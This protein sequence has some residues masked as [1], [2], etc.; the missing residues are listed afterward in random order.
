M[1][2]NLRPLKSGCWTP[3]RLVSVIAAAVLL[4]HGC[5]VSGP[6]TVS[7]S[8]S[9]TNLTFVYLHGFGG[10]KK[11]PAFCDNLKTFIDETECDC[12][13]RNYEWDSVD[14]AITRAGAN[15][16]EA[17]KRAD[18]EAVRFKKTVIN[19][20]ER[21][22]TPYVLVGFSIGSRVIL[23]AM[24]DS[25]GSLKFLRGIYFL[26][27]AMTRDTSINPEYL[28]DGMKIINYHSPLRDKVHRMAFNF[29]EDK[30]AGGCVGFG[31]E[32]VFENYAVSCTHAHKGV[33]V[34]ID[35]SQLAHA[36]GY[37]ALLKE[38]IMIPGETSFNVVTPVGEG[39][40]WWNKI[41]RM[42]YVVD[43]EKNTLE[44]EQ[45]NINADYFRAVAVSPDG[46]RRR[47]ARG[48]NIHAILEELDVMPASYWRN[49]E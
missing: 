13:V 11:D 32:K 20:F 45:H 25:R 44:I 19:S 36:I 41:L 26:G 34:H 37:I 9:D 43:G 12:E 31:D 33:G 49:R 46:D 35:Y 38:R 22:G 39:D 30:P 16:L 29:M 2:S 48:S 28:P 14:I 17:E 10:I 23:R 40:V 6:R 15:W 5:V 4:F 3:V 7:P 24:E 8:S 1:N 42:E 47:V 21:Q 27:S 18:A